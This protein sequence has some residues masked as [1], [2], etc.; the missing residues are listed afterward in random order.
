MA[1]GP[2]ASTNLHHD[3]EFVAENQEIIVDE[4]V[5]FHFPCEWVAITGSYTDDARDETY[6]EE[7]ASCGAVKNVAYEVTI[8]EDS[9]T[10]ADYDNDGIKTVVWEAVDLW[11]DEHI[12]Q[13]PGRHS[14]FGQDVPEAAVELT[15]DPQYPREEIVINVTDADVYGRDGT[16]DYRVVLEKRD[17]YIDGEGDFY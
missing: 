3:H 6:Y 15:V 10:E 9:L 1:L 5:W 12:V 13:Q 8:D 4:D 11:L 7:G 2:S 16:D 17:E 14:T